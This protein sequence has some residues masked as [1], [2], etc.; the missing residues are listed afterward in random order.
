M[1]RPLLG[2][3]GGTRADRNG[4]QSRGQSIT[5][6]YPAP[7]GPGRRAPRCTA[8]HPPIRRTGNRESSVGIVTADTTMATRTWNALRIA[9]TGGRE[10]SRKSSRCTEPAPDGESPGG[11]R[12]LQ[13]VI[14]GQECKG[15]PVDYLVVDHL[16]GF[17]RVDTTQL[18]IEVVR[19]SPRPASANAETAGA[20]SGA[21]PRRVSPRAPP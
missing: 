14:I 12:R 6:V 17:V 20:T 19:G 3:R 15:W 13:G 11:G 8:P 7:G 10:P 5:V 2:R 1:G 21:G 4:R 18:A 9:T 16:A